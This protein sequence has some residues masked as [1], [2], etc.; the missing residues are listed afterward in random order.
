MTHQLFM[1]ASLRTGDAGRRPLTARRY[2]PVGLPGVPG[3]LG[4]LGA[5]D[6]SVE[7][8]LACPVAPPLGVCIEELP[9]AAA[10][11]AL[12]CAVRPAAAFWSRW[13]PASASARD[14]AMIIRAFM[15]SSGKKGSQ[16]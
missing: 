16:S 6:L 5:V 3:L 10:D 2:L 4:R 8:S 9:P 14:A 1:G 13:Q 11:G 12:G 7:P 15:V